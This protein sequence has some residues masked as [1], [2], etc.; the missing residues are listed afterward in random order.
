MASMTFT[1]GLFPL[2]A[3]G[4]LPRCVQSNHSPLKAD[5]FSPAGGWRESQRELN[6]EKSWMQSCWF[7]NGGGF[8]EQRAAPPS[9]RPLTGSKEMGT[10]EPHPQGS[11]FRYPLHDLGNAFFSRA[12]GKEP[13]DT[14]IFSLGDPEQSPQNSHLESCEMINGY[15]FKLLNLL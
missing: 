10:P 3:N 2:M 1:P 7:E 15:C 11:E 5:F 8:S 13:T 12:S 9:P 6:I 4:R 14:T